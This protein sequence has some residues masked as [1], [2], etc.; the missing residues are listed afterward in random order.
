ME[1]LHA[2]VV[3]VI[4][5]KVRPAIRDDCGDIDGIGV[6]EEELIVMVHVTGACEGCSATNVTLEG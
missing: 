5:R 3:D 2:K 6:D 4:D 1:G